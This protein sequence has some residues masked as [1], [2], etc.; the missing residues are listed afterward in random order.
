MFEPCYEHCYLRYSKQYTKECDDKC[1]YA[2]AVKEKKEL[3]ENAIIFPQTIGDITFYSKD[4]LFEWVENMQKEFCSP[5]T[6]LVMGKVDKPIQ[7]VFEGDIKV[8]GDDNNIEVTKRLSKMEAEHLLL[9][10]FGTTDVGVLDCSNKTEEEIAEINRIVDEFNS[11]GCTSFRLTSEELKEVAIS[12]KRFKNYNHEWWA[13]RC[14]RC[15]EI[16]S[17]DFNLD[18]N[19]GNRKCHCSKCGQLCDF[20]DK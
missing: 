4:E 12:V 20:E 7:I 11:I 6:G 15:N 16:I 9:N 19:E 13:G 2:K 18:S 5:P 8:E 17:F 3:I 10:T 1:N 14:P